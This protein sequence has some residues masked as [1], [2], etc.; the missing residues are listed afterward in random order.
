[1]QNGY[2]GTS[3]RDIATASGTNVAMVN[4]YFGSKYNLFGQVFE[5]VFDF[6]VGKVFYTLTSDLP[7]FEM[8][9]AWLDSYY[10]IL[11]EYPQMPNFILNE[12]NINPERMV[13][14]GKDK[15]PL[16]VYDVIKKKIEDEIAKGTIRETSPESLL[17]SILSLGIFPFVFDNIVTVVLNISLENYIDML[18]KHKKFVVEFLK[19]ALKP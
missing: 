6:L 3:V 19:S 12:A 2:N 16:E 15:K 8:L 13:K 11:S 18:R 1:M 7:F 5:E 10:D 4:Y 9:E 17:L 14:I